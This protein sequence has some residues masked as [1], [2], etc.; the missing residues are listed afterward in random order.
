MVA[1][2]RA[3]LAGHPA[4]DSAEADVEALPFREGAFDL[5]IA[6]HMLYHVPDRPRALGELRRVLRPG[7]ALIAA[8]NGERNMRELD[9]IVNATAPDAFIAAWRAGFRL[10][11]TLEN[12][13]EQLAPY[14]HLIEIRHYDDSLEVTEVEPLV[15]YFL[16]ID[17]P[18]IHEPATV[19]AITTTAREVITNGNGVFHISKSVGLFLAMRSA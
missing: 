14:F 7:G 12:G 5:V 18:G 8:T 11:F 9:D 13:G 3:A 1:E 17:A 2:Q 10:P 6:N 4:F 16:S 15:A 19:A